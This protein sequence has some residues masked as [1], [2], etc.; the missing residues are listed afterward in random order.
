MATIHT[1]PSALPVNDPH[2]QNI[3]LALVG[4]GW[5]GGG[6]TFS[7]SGVTGVSAL[8]QSVSSGQSATVTVSKPGITGGTL[9]VSDGTNSG[10]VKVKATRPTKMRY[11][12]GLFIPSPIHRD[13]KETAE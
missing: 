10:T 7:V 2:Q 1:S 5:T 6:T 4:A 12:N 3:R 13:E 11:Y 8:H 9:T